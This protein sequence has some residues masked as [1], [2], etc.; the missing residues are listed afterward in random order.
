MIPAKLQGKPRPESSQNNEGRGSPAEPEG[1]PAAETVDDGW[2]VEAGEPVA[3]DSTATLA[4][5]PPDGSITLNP[6]NPLAVSPRHIVDGN[7]P[8]VFSSPAAS[9]SSPC[10]FFSETYARLDQEDLVGHRPLISH[11]KTNK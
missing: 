8:A 9:H 4:L 6:S 10:T 2:R 7:S 11:C 5:S 1:P 3:P